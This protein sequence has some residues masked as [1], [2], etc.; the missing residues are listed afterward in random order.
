MRE[1]LGSIPSVSMLCFDAEIASETGV[2]FICLE[3]AKCVGSIG[4]EVRAHD[5]RGGTYFSI[6]EF[7]C[8][9]ILVLTVIFRAQA[10]LAQI[11]PRTNEGMKRTGAARVDR[12]CSSPPSSVGRAQ[13][14]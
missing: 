12:R 8:C 7:Y 2:A 6:S 9:A 4:V 1:A 14:P 10:P 13:G 3:D 5:V 11:L